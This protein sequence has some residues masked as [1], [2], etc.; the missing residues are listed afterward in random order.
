M[1]FALYSF[2]ARVDE[3]EIVD[4]LGLSATA[5]LERARDPGRQSNL[6]ETYGVRKISSSAG[7]YVYGGN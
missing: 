1:W 2:A 3:E 5:M 4:I 7:G 6:Q